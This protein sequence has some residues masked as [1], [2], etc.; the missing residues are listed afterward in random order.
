MVSMICYS[1]CSCSGI[2]EQFWDNMVVSVNV[3]HQLSAPHHSSG[4]IKIGPMAWMRFHFRKLPCCLISRIDQRIDQRETPNYLQ[5]SERTYIFSTLEKTLKKTMSWISNMES[6]VPRSKKHIAIS[7]RNHR[8]W[9]SLVIC[10]CTCRARTGT[11]RPAM[12]PVSRSSSQQ[13]PGNLGH[14]RMM[15]CDGWWW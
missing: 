8:R 4:L 3:S 11:G 12:K 7:Q 13:N 14:C 1:T 6:T 5:I 15:G 10:L 2:N 9:A